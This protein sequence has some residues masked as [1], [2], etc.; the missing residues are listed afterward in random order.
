V[1]VTGA[2]NDGLATIL[3]SGDGGL[4]WLRQTNGDVIQAET[5]LG[6]S[7]V[8][9][10][11]AW[12]VG[13]NPNGGYVVLHTGDGGSNWTKMYSLGLG[14]ANEVSAAN[15]AAVWVA[16]E[17]QAAPDCLATNWQPI[18]VATNLTGT[19]LYTNSQADSGNQQFYRA[20]VVR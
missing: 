19:V 1:W 20:R 11:S 4:T 10:S 16:C 5:L 8:D 13:G 15:A 7:A 6:I 12:T 14:D 17:L 2:S 18:W 9:A 3:K